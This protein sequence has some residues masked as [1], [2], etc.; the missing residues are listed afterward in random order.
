MISVDEY[1]LS[2]GRYQGIYHLHSGY[3]KVLNFVNENRA[4]V[5]VVNASISR[6]P[7]R[8][9]LD[10]DIDFLTTNKYEALRICERNLHISDEAIPYELWKAKSLKLSFHYDKVQCVIAYLGKRLQQQEQ[11][12]FDS[13]SKVDQLIVETIKTNLKQGQ[14]ESLLGFGMGLTPLGDDCIFGYLFGMNLFDTSIPDIYSI[15]KEKTTL[16]SSEFLYHMNQ[17]RIS[18]ALYK[19]GKCLFVDEKNVDDYISEILHYGS[20]SGYGILLG[21]KNYLE[22]RSQNV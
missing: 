10:E 11:E 7:A 20:S 9:Q 5:S 19:L 2:D 17:Q 16:I 8:I 6:G 14:L 15:A 21:L 22:R 4:I 13:H 12:L 3:K 1:L 18:D